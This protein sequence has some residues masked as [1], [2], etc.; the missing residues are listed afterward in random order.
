MIEGAAANGSAISIK[1][2]AGGGNDSIVVSGLGSFSAGESSI[3]G[4]AGADT[5]GVTTGSTF[6]LLKTQDGADR[7]IFS[8]GTLIDGKLGAQAD[9]IV[10]LST[11]T[12]TNLGLG[13]GH[14]EISASTIS[15]G[16]AATIKLGEGRDTI[17]LT[18]DAASQTGATILGDGSNGVNANADEIT[19]NLIRF[20][21]NT[22]RWWWRRYSQ[23]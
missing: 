20:R 19:L 23:P 2:E 22:Q 9:S 14:D 13:K 7:V 8:G 4:G 21:H 15:L 11:A 10:F 1:V 17:D 5:I 18:F 3:Y 6:A 16:T 12:V